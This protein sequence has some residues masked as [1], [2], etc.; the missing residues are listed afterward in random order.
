MSL[1]RSHGKMQG[2]VF[3]SDEQRKCAAETPF[4]SAGLAMVMSIMF[5]PVVA[6]VVVSFYRALF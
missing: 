5:W 4:P 2:D 6:G 3:C 1:F